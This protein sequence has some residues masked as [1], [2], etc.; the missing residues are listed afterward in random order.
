MLAFEKSCVDFKLLSLNVRGIRSSAKRKA[1]FCWLNERKCD[2]VFLQETYSTKD[3]ES[4]WKTQWQGKLYF[5][6]GSNH[7]CGVM[8]LVKD[9]VDFK[10]NSIISDDQGRYVIIFSSV[11]KQKYGPL[12]WQFNAS[13]VNDTNFVT[14]LAESILE[15]LNE[16]N[17]VTDKRVLWDLVKYRIRQMSIKYSK[18]RV[19]EKRERV[20]NIENMLRTCEENCSKCPS[21]E[22]FE[23]LEVL[24]IEIDDIYRD[25]AKGAIIRSKATWYEKGKRS[26]KYFLNLESHNKIKSSVRKIFNGEGTLIT[27]LKKYDKK[28]KDFI[29]ISV[30]AIPSRHLRIC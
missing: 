4:I 19:R 25:F 23:Q 27:A 12:F 22:N 14:L 8:I 18:E 1:L 20:S 11:D 6:H 2:I 21:N 30:K 29:P 17:A 26:N 16:F 28:L 9:D 10:L 7:S 3:V 13:L 15:W 5:S 24:K